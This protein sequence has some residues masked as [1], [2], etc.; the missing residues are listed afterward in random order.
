MFPAQN[1]S[2]FQLPM[3]AAGANGSNSDIATSGWKAFPLQFSDTAY[4]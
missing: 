3:P 4:I 2:V 1:T